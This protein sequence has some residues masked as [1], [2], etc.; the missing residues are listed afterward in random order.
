MIGGVPYGLIAYVIGY[1]P[2]KV[3]TPITSWNDLWRPEFAGK[4]AFASPFH[5]M[6]PA[7][8]VIAAE[9][10]GG[11][12]AMSIQGSRSL[13]SCGRPSWVSP[14]PIGRRSTRAAMSSW[15]PSSIAIST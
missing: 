11:R 7:F 1:N 3:K 13:P 10:A 9:L 15:R 5:S 14:G 12:S 8:V 4:L 2:E 6:M